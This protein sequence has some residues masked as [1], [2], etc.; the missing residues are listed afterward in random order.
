MILIRCTVGP[1]GF[2]SA[3]AV[4]LLT[5]PRQHRHTGAI[6][7]PPRSLPFAC[8]IFARPIKT[9]SRWTASTWKC[10]RPNASGCWAP[11][12]RQTTTIEICE[13]L[14]AADSGEVEVLGL[15]GRPTPRHS[16]SASASSFR[17]P[18]SP[19][20]DGA[21]NRPA[22]SQL[23]PA[24]AGSAG[25]HRAG[26]AR[27]EGQIPRG[28]SFGRPEAAAGAGLRPGGQPRFSLP[29]RAHHRP[30]PAG[31]PPALGLIERFKRS[32][33]T[34]LLTTHYMDEAERLCER[35]FTAAFWPI[36]LRPPSC[37]FS[38]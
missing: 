13:G 27:R 9:S 38:V 36:G 31:A 29:R 35:A 25:G 8:T 20:T 23:F 4:S 32:G 26:A 24:G 16:A 1:C 18:S 11:T 28:Q 21:R 33:R 17:K 7:H 5:P 3:I 22:V 10:A 6:P 15:P 2:P 14:T 19:K 30:R 34:I 12:A 37:R